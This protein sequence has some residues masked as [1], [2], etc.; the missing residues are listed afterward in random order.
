LGGGRIEAHG[1]HFR[2]IYFTATDMSSA[3]GGDAVI[4]CSGAST[5][6]S[7][8][9]GGGGRILLRYSAAST[10]DTIISAVGGSCMCV[11]GGT[12]TILDFVQQTLRLRSTSS[13]ISFIAGQF[14]S[15]AIASVTP[16]PRSIFLVPGG[17]TT[18]DLKVLLCQG[19]GVIAGV[20]GV[21]IDTISVQGGAAILGFGNLTLTARRIKVEGRSRLGCVACGIGAG[22][23]VSV[24]S[25]AV[26]C[27]PFNLQAT[28][29][30]LSD[31][32]KSGPYGGGGGGS[33]GA[34]GEIFLGECLRARCG[35]RSASHAGV[36]A[37]PERE[38]DGSGQLPPARRACS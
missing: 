7:G 13:P 9:A 35:T 18:I 27:L 10:A 23:G 5:P 37:A 15:D 38:C 3:A 31:A 2:A 29:L 6:F 1:E 36:Q 25:C 26:N 33:F 12:G 30:V 14:P 22:M 19:T 28:S 21:F 8:G 16:L 24:P 17:N 4:G 20:P 11:G 34:A 32:T